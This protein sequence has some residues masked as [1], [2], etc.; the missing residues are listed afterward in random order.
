MKAFLKSRN[1]NIL[2]SKLYIR[3]LQVTCIKI[4]YNMF[5]FHE[6]DIFP[7]AE[8]CLN[9]NNFAKIA[10]KIAK[11]KYFVDIQNES[12]FPINSLSNDI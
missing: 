7:T 2:R 10:H 3:N 9:F 12:D 5:M 8:N 4:I 6:L 1:L 11:S